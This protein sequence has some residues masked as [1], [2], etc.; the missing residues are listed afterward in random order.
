MKQC[1]KCGTV[2]YSGGTQI[3]VTIMEICP[4]CKKKEEKGHG[5]DTKILTSRCFVPKES[6][7]PG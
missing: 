2:W 4:A 5:Y 3:G 6:L 7:Y 1:T